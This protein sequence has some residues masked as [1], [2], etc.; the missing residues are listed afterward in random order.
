MKLMSFLE[1]IE[2]DKKRKLN[3]MS[4]YLNPTRKQLENLSSLSEESIEDGFKYLGTVSE[5]DLDIY[6]N[7]DTGAILAGVMIDGRFYISLR[8]TC[9][10][11]SLYVRSMQLSDSRKHVKMLNTDK[12]FARQGIAKDVYIFVAQH[13][14]LVSDRVQYL[15]AKVLWQSLAKSSP[16]N[17]YV[18]DESTK[19]YIRDS[20]GDIINYNGSNI[21]ENLIWG[22]TNQH[23]DRLLVATVRKLL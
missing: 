4:P 10:E 5:Q 8:I 21:D 3:E 14:D 11:R 22:Q 7:E 23:H 20:L 12:D 13:F 6:E 15:G 1:F 9:E 17:V 19:D 18:F 2:Y 16:I